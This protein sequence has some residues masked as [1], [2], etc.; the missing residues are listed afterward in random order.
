MISAKVEEL[1]NMSELENF[2]YQDLKWLRTVC[3]Q[4]MLEL[5]W[6]MKPIRESYFRENI[7]V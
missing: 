6:K 1:A 3:I 7:I 4:I 5:L 2:S